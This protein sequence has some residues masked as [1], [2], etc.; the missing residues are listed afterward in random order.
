MV[1]L[2]KDSEDLLQL[3]NILHE[4]IIRIYNVPALALMLVRQSIILVSTAFT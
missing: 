4:S 2:R 3:I 1:I